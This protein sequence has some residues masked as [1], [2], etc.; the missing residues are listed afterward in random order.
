MPRFSDSSSSSITK[1]F[2][3]HSSLRLRHSTAFFVT[4]RTCRVNER[5]R[6]STLESITITVQSM[7]SLTRNCRETSSSGEKEIIE[8]VPGKSTTE[9]LLS[10]IFVHPF[11]Y[12]T[13]LP[14]QLPVCC[15]IPVRALKIVLFPTLGLPASTTL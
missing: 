7:S 14:V 15:F 5:F 11:A 12:S 4:E 2:L 10:L 13:V 6:S 8:Y 9:K 3:Q 1:P